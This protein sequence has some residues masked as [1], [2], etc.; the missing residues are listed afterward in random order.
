M[1]HHKLLLVALN[2]ISFK[3]K[4]LHEKLW[5]SRKFVVKLSEYTTLTLLGELL[6]L[7]SVVYFSE[8][9]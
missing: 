8:V 1:L 3:L 9:S 6:T 4:L 7:C 5:Y 2:K